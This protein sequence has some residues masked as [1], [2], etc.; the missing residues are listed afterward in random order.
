MATSAAHWTVEKM[1][2]RVKKLRNLQP[3]IGK[4]VIAQFLGKDIFDKDSW[5]D[6]EEEICMPDE[7][8]IRAVMCFA[9]M[10]PMDLKLP[11]KHP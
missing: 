5:G 11:S 6:D 3:T 8:S 1:A 9:L 7:F 4:A 2:P 10:K